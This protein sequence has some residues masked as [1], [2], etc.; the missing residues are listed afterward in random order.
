MLRPLL[1]LPVAALLAGCGTLINHPTQPVEFTL[2]HCPARVDVACEAQN[3]R[4]HWEFS[5]PATLEI[6]RSDDALQVSCTVNDRP[7]RAG[8]RSVDSRIGIEMAFSVLLLDGGVTDWYTD[9]HRHYPKTVPL[10]VC[11]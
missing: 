7:E 2:P 11:L 9:R 8:V 4:G 6:A 10:P 1:V 5:P 3:K